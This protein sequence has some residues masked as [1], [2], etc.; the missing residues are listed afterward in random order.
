[1]ENDHPILKRIN[2]ADAALAANAEKRRN[3]DMEDARLLARREAYAD[4]YA[5]V[6]GKSLTDIEPLPP[7]RPRKASGGRRGMSHMWQ[8]LLSEAAT[9]LVAEFGVDEVMSVAEAF[10]ADAPS[11]SAI[12]SQLANYANRGTVERIS[13]GVFRL[14]P[15]GAEELGL[16]FSEEAEA[17][18]EDAPPNAGGAD[19]GEVG[20]P[21]VET[22]GQREED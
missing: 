7:A 10:G 19:T 20:T 8:R 6:S 21:S 14:T 2:E 18:E 9:P 13:N 17:S 3:L 5:L 1:M 22:P 16:E 4:A 11:R 12:R 15:K